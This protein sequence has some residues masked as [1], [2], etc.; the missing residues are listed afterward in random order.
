MRSFFVVGA[1]LCLLGVAMG[2][3]G[4]HALKGSLSVSELETFK[5][6]VQYHQFHALAIVVMSLGL[7]GFSRPK[8]VHFGLWLFLAG[9][10]L[11]AGSLY[12]LAILHMPAL[13]AITPFG[14]I[15]FM[16]G[17]ILFAIHG[18]RMGSTTGRNQ[19]LA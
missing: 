15:C 19:D 4:A 1:V 18:W 11:F 14:G 7:G 2:A 8:L 9:I 10:A 6:G 12:L 17:W 16:A 3:F 13:G 5:T